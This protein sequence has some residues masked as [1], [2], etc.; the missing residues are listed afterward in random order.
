[1]GKIANEIIL[2]KWNIKDAKELSRIG[3]NYKIFSR[4]TDAFPH[5]YTVAKAKKYIENT[6]KNKKA[7]FFAIEFEEKVIG[8]I[9]VTFYDD[10][11]RK[12]AELAYFLSEEYW[13]R[14]IMAKVIRSICK[15]V[16]EKYIDITRIFAVP[17]GKNMASRKVLENA[18]FRLEGILREN[19]IKNKKIDDTYVF[20]ILRKEYQ[21]SLRSS[22]RDG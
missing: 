17:F 11:Y 15:I 16:F 10:V 14:K 6:E 8:S 13:G 12:N 19:V 9:G 18:G 1:M 21:V 2:R 4:L 3:N 20:S 7:Y 5:P 22:K